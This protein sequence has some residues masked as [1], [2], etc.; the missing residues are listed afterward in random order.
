MTAPLSSLDLALGPDRSL[1]A[2]QEDIAGRLAAD[3][4]LADVLVLSERKGDLSSDDR[5]KK[6]DE[7]ETGRIGLNAKDLEA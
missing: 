5:G 4:L 1:A 6:M 2:L 3:E 7:G